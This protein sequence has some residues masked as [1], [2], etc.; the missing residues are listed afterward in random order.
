MK[1]KLYLLTFFLIPLYSFSQNSLSGHVTH[2]DTKEAVIGASIFIPELRIG[3]TT[4]LKGEYRLTKLPKGTFTAQVSYVS[5]KTLVEKIV[6]EGNVVKDFV[7]ENSATSIEEVIVTGSS[8][9]TLIK[10]SPIPVTALSRIQ[11]MQSSS[12]NLVDAVAKL[13]GVSSI[14][15]GAGL[16]KPVIRGLAFNRVITMHD[17]IRQED[18]QWGEEH[19]INLDEYSIDRYEIIRGAG[20]L[21]YGSDGLGGVIAIYSPRPVEE[22]KIIGRVLGNY[23]TNNGLYGLSAQL[24]GNKNGLHWLIN[25]SHK[26][27]G[28]F[29]TPV[30]GRVY[31][32]NYRELLNFNGFV[33]IN[34]SW[35]YSRLY[36][37]RT[38]QEYNIT[39]GT[40]DAN[41]RFTKAIILP[42][43]N[44][45]EAAVSDAELNSRELIP[46]NSQYLLNSKISSNSYFQLG[47]SNLSLNL[48]YAQNR[49][50]EYGN[51]FTPW[52][53]DLYFFLQTYYYDLRYNLPVKNNWETTLGTNGMYQTMNNR[54][55]NALYPDY[56]LFDNGVFAFTKKSYDRLKLSGGI[57][58]D[59]RKLDIN[60]L[61]VNK[62]GTFQTSPVGAVETRF[63]GANN[64]YQNVSWS[65]GGVYNINTKLLL[66]ANVSRG[67]RSPAVPELSSNGEHAGTFR[68]EIGNPNAV[69]EVAHQGDLGF[70]YEHKGVYFDFSVFQNSIQNYTYSE[71]VQNN[72]GRDSINN[73]VPVFRY[74]QGDARLQ[75]VEA[76]LTLNPTVARWFSFTQTYSSVFAVNLAAKNDDAKYLPF[77]PSPRWISQFKIT[78]DRF[79]N[80]FR[81]LYASLGVE[82]YQKQDRVL[83]A[84]NTETPTP[85][86]T[87]TNLGF[88]ADVTA[89]SKKTLFSVYVS[90]TNIF[91]V[92]YQNH[93]SR[94]KY[95]D[96]NPLTGRRGIYGMGRNVSVKLVVPIEL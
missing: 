28:N 29:R 80:R 54:G 1:T 43:G 81:N 40:R 48:S 49:R 79:K 88:G 32:T 10:E 73:G 33:G 87:L 91:D 89:N 70:T 90:A 13:P 78:R 71:R 66:R 50:L 15:T 27:A 30:D 92:A 21:M 55:K 60:A 2:I 46:F 56:S 52:V 84:F 7:M 85:G 95:L 11:W 45:G 4:D 94:F 53:P 58:F 93:Q 65:F 20:S 86:Y 19:S 34:K 42:D 76:T 64:L 23:Q 83:L 16:S 35:G 75:G 5:H 51:V 69:P 24:A 68:Y 25:G 63:K 62:S 6:I 14:S 22:G 18:N 37:L 74:T 61:Y 26:N 44:G 39:N 47:K 96:V 77:I 36:F 67:F 72:A 38:K 41:G 8:T 9:K 31:S 17:G 3:A 57:R 12:T 59:I 82:I